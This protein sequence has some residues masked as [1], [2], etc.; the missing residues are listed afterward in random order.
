MRSPPDLEWFKYDQNGK[1]LSPQPER[2]TVWAH[3]GHGDISDLDASSALDFVDDNCGLDSIEMGVSIGVAMETGM[4]KF[5]EAEGAINLVKG[6][7]Q[8]TPSGRLVGAGAAVMDKV[9]GSELSEPHRS[10]TAIRCSPGRP[11]H[12]LE[13]RGRRR[14]ETHDHQRLLPCVL[15]SVLPIGGNENHISRAEINPFLSLEN[16]ALS[17]V[18]ELLMLPGMLVGWDNSPRRQFDHAHAEVVGSI[19]FPD[20]HPPR[21]PLSRTCK[22]SRFDL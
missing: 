17:G 12:R 21:H 5:G 11:E 19:R 6:V 8:G 14:Y 10:L 20:D 16:T 3:G 15:Q 18:H 9:F 4:I 2:E 22:R 7:G 1:F 13:L